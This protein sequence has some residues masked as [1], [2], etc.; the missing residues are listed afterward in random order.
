MTN[1]GLAEQVIV[2][3]IEKFGKVRVENTKV[4][5]ALEEGIHFGK[6]KDPKWLVD[7]LRNTGDQGDFRE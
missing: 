4:S 2:K 1:G 3:T 6:L 7:V 5:A